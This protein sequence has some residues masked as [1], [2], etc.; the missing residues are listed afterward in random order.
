M[1]I[2]IL[3]KPSIPMSLKLT[4]HG[5][6]KITSTSNKTKR[7]ATKKYLTENGIRAL[8]VDSIPHSKLLSLL[9]DDLFGPKRLEITIV[10]PM[11]SNGK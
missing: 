10:P 7:M 2:P 4:A 8:P 11:K 5:Y 6:M 9:A 1:K 3:I